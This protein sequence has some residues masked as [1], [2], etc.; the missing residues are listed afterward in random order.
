ML[1]NIPSS[2]SGSFATK[3]LA[4][5]SQWA[6]VSLAS[7]VPKDLPGF[8]EPSS[9]ER[10][11]LCSVV[12]PH[13]RDLLN[14]DRCLAL[15]QEQTLDRDSFEVIV[16]ENGPP[17]DI[18]AVVRCVAG[19]ARLIVCSERGAGPARN[20][21]AIASRGRIL[22]FVD[23]DCRPEPDFLVRGLEALGASDIVGGS[24]RVTVKDTASVT[25]AEAFELV[26]AFQNDK[27]IAKKKFSVSAALFVSRRIFYHVGPFRAGM[28][29]DLEWCRRAHRS[30]YS[31]AFA[32]GAVV[33]HPARRSWDDIATKWRRLTTESFAFIREQPFGTAAW[34]LRTYVLPL[35]IVPHL[36]TIFR[37]PKLHRMSDRVGA[38][39]VLC[40]LR[41]A[42]FVWGHLVILSKL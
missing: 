15:L 21:G 31:L 18:E 35:S 2:V 6:P 22:A 29:E 38:A 34:L 41:L 20:A 13:F 11:P 7:E 14:L 39:C 37:S 8:N 9:S 33:H 16:A 10:R 17:D 4:L 32:P 26:F 25:P 12:V 5:D 3:P 1:I 30:G 42:R 40:R 23:S 28:S 36:V 27:Y 19:R 24:I